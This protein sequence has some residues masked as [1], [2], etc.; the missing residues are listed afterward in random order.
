MLGSIFGFICV[1]LYTRRNLLSWPAGLIQVL[2]FVY[3]FYE[4]KLY[5]D[6][7]L[8]IVFVFLQIYGWVNWA[9]E[10][11]TKGDIQIRRLNYK[12]FFLTGIIGIVC[13]YLLGTGMQNWTDA[14]FPY[15]DAGL[16][17]FSLIAQWMIAKKILENWLYWIIIDICSIALYAF[18]E[19]YFTCGLYFLFFIL[20]I[21]G[22]YSWS[23]SINKKDQFL[24]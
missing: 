1:A 11:E 2:I 6:M 23:L 20:S 21:I 8:H 5:S 18:K 17:V 19:L 10:K 13:T 24:S 4:V 9:N 16:A 15:T 14:S 12:I 22:Y 3:V 7:F